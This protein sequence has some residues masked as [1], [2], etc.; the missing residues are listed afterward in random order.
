[1]GIR[2]VCNEKPSFYPVHCNPGVSGISREAYQVK[3]VDIEVAFVQCLRYQAFEGK[4]DGVDAVR[5]CK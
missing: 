3:A 4:V 2:L 5:L 1:M